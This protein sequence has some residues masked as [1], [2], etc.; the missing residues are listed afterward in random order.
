MVICSVQS[1]IELLLYRYR[2]LCEFFWGGKLG[3]GQLGRKLWSCVPGVED[4]H[5]IIYGSIMVMKSKIIR[6]LGGV[7][8]KGKYRLMSEFNSIN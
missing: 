5:S 4:L 2:A 8:R 6:L 3:C 7:K 1:E